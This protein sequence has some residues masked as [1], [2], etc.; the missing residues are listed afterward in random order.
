MSSSGGVGSNISPIPSTATVGT[1]DYYVSQ[2]GILSGCESPRQKLSVIVVPSPNAP[3]VS[4]VSY[5]SG[6]TSVGLTSAANTGNSLLW[7]GLSA[8]GGIGSSISPVPSTSSAGVFDYYVSQRETSTGCESIRSKLTV[9]INATP[10]APVVSSVSYCTGIPA[11]VLSGTSSSGNSLVWYGMSS[12][13]GTG[14][15]SA[16]IPITTTAGSF[17]Y[18]VSQKNNSS[19]CES[20]RSKITVTVNSIPLAPIISKDN[21]NNLLSSSVSG[22]QWFV[23]GVLLSGATTSNIK[24]I[25]SGNYTVQVTLNGCKSNFSEMYYYLIS[26]IVNFSNGDFI[27]TYPN[28]VMNDLKFDFNIN[29]TSNLFIDLIDIN[30]RIILN[31]ISINKN[32]NISFNYYGPGI[33]LLKFYNKKSKLIYTAKI[34]KD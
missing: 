17:D 6:S 7:Y 8:T 22:N 12:T 3:T 24:P 18:F 15:S 27:R 21:S 23:D 30:G 16:P 25:S 14:N 1:F 9:T 31:K 34:I 28:P 33:Y 2:K 10:S 19:G 5:C 32:S 11:N 29:G 4:G 26:N 20:P 13:G